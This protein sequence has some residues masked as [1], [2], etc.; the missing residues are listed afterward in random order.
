[1]ATLEEVLAEGEDYRKKYKKKE[2]TSLDEIKKS[3]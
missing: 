1:M 3:R 2:K